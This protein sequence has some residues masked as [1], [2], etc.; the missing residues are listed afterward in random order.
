M[1]QT[2]LLTKTNAEST[3]RFARTTNQF[4]NTLLLRKDFLVEL[5][6]EDETNKAHLTKFINKIQDIYA[7]T[8]EFVIIY[9][10]EFLN[11]IASPANLDSS[12]LRNRLLVL[13]RRFQVERIA[14]YSSA[15]CIESHFS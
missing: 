9:K 15:I 10:L 14:N 8:D 2:T 11:L 3:K 7:K 5:K 13:Y 1:T 12:K 6:C 4:E